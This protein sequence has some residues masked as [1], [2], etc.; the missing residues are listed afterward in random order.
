MSEKTSL[1]FSEWA[2]PTK[3][4][5]KQLLA[6]SPS[7][8]LAHTL[9][10]NLSIYQET[11]NGFSSL[12][13]W[14]PFENSNTITAICWYDATNIPEVAVPVLVIASESK[15]IIVYDFCAQKEIVSFT[16]KREAATIIKWSPISSSRFF[17][18]TAAGELLCCSIS[19]EQVVTFTV[20]LTIDL[21]FQIDFLSFE[22]TFADNV[23]VASKAGQLNFIAGIH[24]QEPQ[25]SQESYFLCDNNNEI[26][27][28]DFLEASQNYLIVVTKL[29]TILYTIREQAS[30]NLLKDQKILY[31][32]PVASHGCKLIGVNNETMALY[33]FHDGKVIR[34]YEITTTPTVTNLPHDYQP[35]YICK[36][37]K[38]IFVSWNWWLTTVKVHND[39]LFIAS[40]KKLLNEKPTNFCFRGGGMLICSMNGSVFATK[41]TPS[42]VQIPLK[43]KKS[44]QDD[45]TGTNTPG[46]MNKPKRSR[47]N[48]S[49]EAIQR[50]SCEVDLKMLSGEINHDME[51]IAQQSIV[52]RQRRRLSKIAKKALPDF[53]EGT[54]LFN[55]QVVPAKLVNDEYLIT[56]NG[57][58]PILQ[59][60][61]KKDESE[62]P[63]EQQKEQPKQET[64]PQPKQE[65]TQAPQHPQQ[66]QQQQPQQQQ[67]KE[68][69]G[70]GGEKPPIPKSPKKSIPKAP[71]SSQN[72][73]SPQQKHVPSKQQLKQTSQ[74][75]QPKQQTDQ[76]KTETRPPAPTQTDSNPAPASTPENENNE[77][78][79]SF[80]APPPL[81]SSEALGPALGSGNANTSSIP[82]FTPM[83]GLP[84]P[85]R[86]RGPRFVNNAE[87]TENQETIPSF[88]APL[89]NQFRNAH[90]DQ[91]LLANSRRQRALSMRTK[92]SGQNNDQIKMIADNAKKVFYGNRALEPIRYGNSR[93]IYLHF[94][95]CD[96]PLK[97]VEWISP[98]KILAYGTETKKGHIYNH[99]Y[100]INVKTRKVNPVLGERLNIFNLPI[101]SIVL[102]DNKQL[103]AIIMNENLV[104]FINLVQSV[105]TMIWSSTFSSKVMVSF[106]SQN[107]RA[108]L[109]HEAKIKFVEFDKNL[110]HM[111]VTSTHKLEKVKKVNAVLWKKN[112]L[113]IGCTTGKLF[114][115]DFNPYQLTEI[116]NI[117]NS[118]VSI[119]NHTAT[120]MIVTDI[121]NNA[122]IISR[123][124]AIEAMVP[125]PIK[126]IHPSSPEEFV[127]RPVGKGVLSVL[128][129]YTPQTKDK[130]MKSLYSFESIKPHYSPV[131]TRCMIMRPRNVWSVLFKDAVTAMTNGSPN[132]RDVIRLTEVFGIPHAR[133]IINSMKYPLRKRQQL[134]SIRDLVSTNSELNQLT[135]HINMK[136][137]DS[138]KARVIALQTPKDSPFH[139][140]NI[141]KSILLQTTPNSV[142]VREAVGQ[143]FLDD[144][145]DDAIEILMLSGMWKDAVTKLVEI[146]SIKEAMSLT[147]IRS[148]NTDEMFEQLKEILQKLIETKYSGE[149]LILAAMN[150]GM[151]KVSAKLIDL[152][153]QEQADLLTKVSEYKLY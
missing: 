51:I 98:V 61:K 130:N 17:I 30:F 76:Q 82:S 135:M 21:G 83:K 99:L 27:S 63:K 118:V 104:T 18:G 71:T 33:Q 75:Q 13:S 59:E 123:S 121:K 142:A 5:Q 28:I 62:Q 147:N 112:S 136:L 139:I 29:G 87:G 113:I 40:R 115:I 103:A 145:S 150:G 108:L 137:G 153:E 78:V 90:A 53:K 141:Y 16:L 56:L 125:F 25:I 7:G 8:L 73:P 3:K 140:M 126:E 45:N 114:T 74:A 110:Q 85:G 94:K 66:Q 77:A 72:D 50:V 47:K 41:P 89:P 152:G 65:Q 143:L 93:S 58:A 31:L 46:P 55:G 35:T 44:N 24:T 86:R 49:D 105:P 26:Y 19:L 128:K 38:I 37:D 60:N 106:A 88:A 96:C 48:S 4:L 54:Q 117:K 43:R 124:G 79:P 120:N 68:Q 64:K 67:T 95:I 134:S 80:D 69:G 146:G 39:K 32:F 97:M 81:T 1:S 131:I 10:G 52:S 20:D 9:D 116:A 149:G 42:A 91:Q 127:I 2:Y 109:F 70:E 144:F 132:V 129:T 151:S 11:E 92:N 57:K 34:L 119:V 84:L 138:E 36:N 102:S 6:L 23:L 100:I 107:N 101:T 14:A 15:K 22:P 111:R 133:N 12:I 122:Y 148:Q